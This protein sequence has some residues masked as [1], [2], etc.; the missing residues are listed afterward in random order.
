MEGELVVRPA[1]PDIRRHVARYWGYA[2]DT[3]RPVQQREPISPRVVL[4]FGL[5]SELT[6]DDGTRVRSFAAGLDD[7]CAVIRHDGTMRGV[8][9]DLSPPAARML[10]RFPMHELAGRVVTVDE[11]LGRDGLL[12]EEALTVASTW[13]ERFAIL[14]RWLARRLSRVDEPPAD[15]TWA[16][17]RLTET[18]GRLRVDELARELGCSRKHLA[19]RFREHVGVPPKLVARLHRF[20]R[21]LDLLET[22][23]DSIAAVAFGAGYYDESHLDRDFRAFAGTTPAAWRDD[24]RAVTF[25]QDAA[26]AAA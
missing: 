14:D 6:L 5:D 23:D 21:A 25:V 16:W 20:R 15:V 17:R 24:P 26:V 19:V 1:A 4:I 3:G 22:S 10:F 13:D 8:Q 12:L 9:I 11:L 18:R 7:R 2:Q